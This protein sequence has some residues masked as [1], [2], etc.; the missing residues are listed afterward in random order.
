MRKHK[1]LIVFFIVGLVLG[2]LIAHCYMLP[3]TS[4]AINRDASDSGYSQSFNVSV[5]IN[6]NLE[7]FAV[8][9]ILAFNGSDPFILAPKSYV[10]SVLSYFGPYKNSEAVQYVKAVFGNSPYYYRDTLIMEWSNRLVQLNYL[11]NESQNSLGFEFRLLAEFAN[12]SN[13]LKFY[14]A[15]KREYRNAIRGIQ[16]SKAFRTFPELLKKLFG[17]SYREYKIEYS[18]SLRIHGHAMTTNETA[19]YIGSVP[20]PTNV[21]KSRTLQDQ[22]EEITIL[23]EFSHPYVGKALSSLN[24][25]NLSYYVKTAQNELPLLVIADDWHVRNID[26]YMNELLTEGLAIYMAEN[27]NISQGIIKFRLLRDLVL[28]YPLPYVI[29]EYKIFAHNNMTLP[30][31]LPILMSKMQKIATPDNVSEYYEQKVPVTW[32]GTINHVVMTGKV[33]IVYGEGYETLALQL[34]SSL[35]RTLE[36]EGVYNIQIG[37][38]NPD[39]ITAS[40]LKEDLI[41]VGTPADNSILKKLN[42]LMPFRVASHGDGWSI[43]ENHGV[44]EDLYSFNM[45]TLSEIHSNSKILC[46]NGGWIIEVLRNPW[47]MENFITVFIP[48]DSKS[49][50]P[51]LRYLGLP[52]SYILYCNGEYIEGFYTQRR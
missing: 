30:K 33:I 47:E 17:Y 28:L 36:D 22:F 6:P 27:L 14:D 32:Y 23:H 39:N 48:F 43:T 7:L 49:E 42:G 1:G 34:K 19:Y 40:Q 25:S 11:A 2:I 51:F 12:E 46:N 31:S 41:L 8:V 5:E 50:N 20:Q 15:H 38:T 9:Y 16:E 29:T 45:S 26:N 24:L 3:R 21:V 13:F 44:V 18:Y 52:S 35:E 10:E 4:I 37:V